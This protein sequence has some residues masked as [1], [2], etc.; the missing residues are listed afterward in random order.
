M[1]RLGGHDLIRL[2][3]VSQL[4]DQVEPIEQDLIRLVEDGTLD[5]NGIQR[6]PS[7]IFFNFLKDRN[8]EKNLAPLGSFIVCLCFNLF[9]SIRDIFGQLKFKPLR[10]P[11]SLSNSFG[12]GS[13]YNPNSLT[14]PYGT[15]GSPYSDRS[16]TNPF[17]TNPP[18]LY[19][20]Q[21]QYRGNLSANPYDPNS[22]S[23]P[24]GRY[25]SKYSPDSL[26]N[27]FGAGSPYKQDSPNNRF[28]K[29]LSGWGQ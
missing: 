25:G 8:Y 14:N 11:N 3:E 26:N 16:S 13:P 20:S 12:T 2:V 9:R 17:A 4:V 7:S 29:G 15:F 27:P 1:L 19:D 18:K 5:V 10:A 21:G 22:T 6:D 28:G 24:Y 23:N